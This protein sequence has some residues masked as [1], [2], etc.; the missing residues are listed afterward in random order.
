[1]SMWTILPRLIVKSQATLGRQATTHPTLP[2]A[3]RDRHRAARS[4]PHTGGDRVVI[5]SGTCTRALEI[6]RATRNAAEMQS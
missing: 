4:S 3:E 1:M 6:T 2:A 5:L